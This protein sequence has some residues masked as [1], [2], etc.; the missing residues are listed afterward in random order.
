MI[1]EVKCPNCGDVVSIRVG[2]PHTF[3]RIATCK[4]CKLGYVLRVKTIVEVKVLKIEGEEE[5][6]SE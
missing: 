3:Q 5:S 1:K 2:S 4:K 6:K